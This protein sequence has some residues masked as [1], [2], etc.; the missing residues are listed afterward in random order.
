MPTIFF[1][2]RPRRRGFV[3][4]R[5]ALRKTLNTIEISA[6]QRVFLAAIFT[7]NMLIF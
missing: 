5:A 7:A 1:L 3:K 4:A 2:F 6:I